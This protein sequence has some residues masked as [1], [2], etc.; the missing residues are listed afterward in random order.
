MSSGMHIFSELSE[1][2]L[3]MGNEVLCLE[4]SVDYLIGG[5]GRQVSFICR[6]IGY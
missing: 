2:L 1:L 3:I 6:S 4:G 5:R